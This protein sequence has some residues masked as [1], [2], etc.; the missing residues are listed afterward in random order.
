MTTIPQLQ[1][2]P[3]VG[4]GDLVPLSQNGNLYAATV[5]QLTAGL[6]AEI[7]LPTGDILGR[8]SAG[9]GEP[10]ALGLGAGLVLEATTLAATGAD[11]LAFPLLGTF[12]ASTEVIVNA[13][14]QP[15]RL[16]VTE[17]R[18]LF[19]AGSGIAID[20]NG[21]LSVTA[22]AIAGPAGPEGPA[23]PA[24]PQGANG[25]SGPQ[26]AGLTAPGSANAAS[27]IAG[28]DYVA[29]WQN[30]ANAWI[31][32]QQLIG[33]QTIDQLPAAGPAA[34]SDLLLVA[35]GG[36]ALSSQSFAAIWTYAAQKIPTLRQ[37]VVEL[38]TNTV[39]DA[40]THNQR[41]LVASQPITVSAN[42]VN[43]GSG[44]SCRVI[45][46]S[47]GAVTM[48]TGITSGSG[49][50]VLAPGAAAELTALSYSGG[51]IVWWSGAAAVAPTITVNAIAS[52]APNAAFAVSGDLFD[53]APAAL[54]YSTDGMTWTAAASPAI[55]ASSYSF[56]MPGL[57]VGTYTLRVRDHTNPAVVGVSPAFSVIAAPS[58]S[59]TINQPATTSFAAGSGT[60][61][62]NG[63]IS[64]A[65]ATATQVALSTSNTTPPASGWQA[66]SIIDNDA[67][68]AVYATI[69]ATAGTYYVW[70]ETGT[71]AAATV[72]SF[73]I[74][75]T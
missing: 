26:G 10:E 22:G 47:A 17:L 11:H 46:L 54:D 2:A 65:Q 42:F 50:S 43:M 44:F 48:G 28:S 29:I 63:G 72:S 49:G 16:P 7:L 32:Y 71:G 1:A 15:A 13:A 12:S 20:A 30:G 21:T 5:A 38:T 64:P 73:T 41:I 70:V 75:V 6:Q 31:T 74:T 3:D 60:V 45:N 34:D 58:V 56:Q 25:P 68:W 4:P 67:L 24:G 8:A 14:G 62:L 35:Q 40:T 66:A 27:T 59:Y 39:L 53:A 9:A 51:S 61:A 55:T 52:P 37:G 19:A 23:G 18:G 36:N 33:G 69:P 57:V